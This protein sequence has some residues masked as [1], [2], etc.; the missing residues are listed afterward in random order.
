MITSIVVPCVSD[1]TFFNKIFPQN[2]EFLKIYIWKNFLK[3][4]R[5]AQKVDNWDSSVNLNKNKTI[6]P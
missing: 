4:G 3:C 1:M 5:I 2:C 6:L